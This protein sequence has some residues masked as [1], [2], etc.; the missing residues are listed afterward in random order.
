MQEEEKQILE[1]FEERLKLLLGKYKEL[2]S[3]NQELARQI[4]EKEEQ[5]TGL[6]SRFT[7]LEQMYNNLKQ[8]RMISLSYEEVDNAQEHI[9]RLV[10][11]IDQCIE[12]LTKQP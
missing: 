2:K 6:Q 1:Q 7:N 11:E 10:R 12:T 9:S 5:L 3:E 8:A 4:A